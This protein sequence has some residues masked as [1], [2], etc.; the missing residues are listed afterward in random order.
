MLSC[1]NKASVNASSWST[2]TSVRSSCAVVALHA[3]VL[4]KRRRGAF[5]LRC[6][7]PRFVPTFFLGD[8]ARGDEGMT[9]RMQVGGRYK[10]RTAH[11]LNQIAIDAGASLA[12]IQPW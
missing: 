4:M 7:R 8:G 1:L 9:A 12:Q 10:L 6:N 3:A 2:C 5:V 11:C